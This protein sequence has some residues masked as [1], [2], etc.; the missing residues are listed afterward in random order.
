MLEIFLDGLYILSRNLGI[1]LILIAVFSVNILFSKAKQDIS[2][3]LLFPFLLIS[4]LLRLAYLRDIFVP[5][6][7]DSVEHLRIINEII[8]G[9]ED[10]VL[11]D[12]LPSIIPT[13][14][15]LGFHFFASF[16]TLGLRADSTNV[17]L[18]IGQSI[19]AFIPVP[20]YF[21]VYGETKKKSASFLAALLAGFGWY[22]PAFAINW[23]KYPAIMG[24]LA[25]E[26]VLFQMRLGKKKGTQIILLILGIIIATLIH[27][28][29]AVLFLISFLSWTFSKETISLPKDTQKSILRIQLY[30]IFIF[31]LLIQKD[32]LLKLSLEPYLDKGIYITIAVLILS[33][34]AFKKYPRG[35]Y[36]NL[37]FTL[38]LFTS[39][40]IPLD[41][42]LPI[43]TNQTLLD[44][45]FVEMILYLPLSLLGGLGIA[46]ILESLKFSRSGVYKYLPSLASFAI[47]FLVGVF[48]L[49][50]YD[51]NPSQCCGFVSYDDTIIFDWIDRNL[52][53][54]VH[55]LIAGNELSVVPSAESTSLVGSD[56]GIWIPHLAKREIT[57]LSYGLDFSS[58]ETHNL[59]CQHQ[60]NYIYFGNKSQS[61]HYTELEGKDE[62]YKKIVS[63]SKAQLYEL[64]GCASRK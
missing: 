25:F 5:P 59:L 8:A 18:I 42:I 54:D 23:G 14:Y 36:F 20:V 60:I 49:K 17:M 29:T 21:L 52:P 61:F 39:L 16:L 1:I 11:W 57:M 33:F 32:P 2:L 38:F 40:F 62:W 12:S 13:Y 28:R 50:S 26:L 45:P 15:H 53:E 35:L 3:N 41:G 7:F 9:L 31:G 24:L 27:S 30:V 63:L 58:A 34:F 51:F 6:Y 46:G 10:G 55:I 56:A 48:S 44:R 19:L 47:I 37:F 4:L 64:T 43:F 22:M